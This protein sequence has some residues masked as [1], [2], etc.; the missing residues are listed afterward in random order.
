MRK[1]L[2]ITINLNGINRNLEVE[3]R[4]LLS[5]VLREDLGLTGTHVSCEIGVCG[6]CTVVMNGKTCRSC[7]PLAVQ[8]NGAEIMTV[9]AMNQDKGLNYIQQAFHDNH[10]LQCGFCTPGFLIVLDALF[11]KKKDPSDDEINEALS[12][13][14]C[15]CTGYKNIFLAA[16]DVREKLRNI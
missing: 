16:C 7:L 12:D 1:K 11:S 8:A 5:D 4:R 13:V 3:P 6:V 9:E 10:A 2:K 14:L 15:R